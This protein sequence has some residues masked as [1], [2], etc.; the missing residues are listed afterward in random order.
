MGV[1]IQKDAL[2]VLNRASVS[3]NLDIGGHIRGFSREVIRQS[4][5]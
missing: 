3:G 4:A 2:A 1:K 5:D